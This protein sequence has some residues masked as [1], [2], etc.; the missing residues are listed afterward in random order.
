MKLLVTTLVFLFSVNAQANLESALQALDSKTKQ[1]LEK[2]E[3]N[4]RKIDDPWLV[5]KDSTSRKVALLLIK[6][7][8]MQFCVESEEKELVYQLYL[9]SL[10]NGDSKLLTDWFQFRQSG[11][12]A[13][14]KDLIDTEFLNN[15]ERLRESGL[16]GESFDVK[17]ALSAI[18][19]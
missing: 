5:S 8:L 16:F 13:V 18:D 12:L 17:E 9:K 6:D 19:K 1:C 10:R 7:R 2:P 15:I 11:L 14:H 3:T 4:F